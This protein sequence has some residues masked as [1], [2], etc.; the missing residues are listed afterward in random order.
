MWACER[1]HALGDPHGNVREG[2][3][4]D[5]TH[6]QAIHSQAIIS[7]GASLRRYKQVPY[8]ECAFR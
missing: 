6:G 2:T 7:S 4:E 3:D 5:G 1:I 8:M